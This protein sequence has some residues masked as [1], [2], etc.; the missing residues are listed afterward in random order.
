MS[1]RPDRAFFI[2]WGRRGSLSVVVADLAA[3][4]FNQSDRLDAVSYSTNNE[5]A[6]ELGTFRP[7]A[8]PFKTFS[9]GMGALTGL[10]RF[11]AEAQDLVSDLQA[12]GYSTAIVLMPHL[13]TPLLGPMLRRAGIRYTVVVHDAVRHPGDHT[14]IVTRWLLRDLN[15]ANL[16][17][18]LSKAV[19]DQLLAQRRVSPDRVAVVPHPA[20]SYSRSAG[21]RRKHEPLRVLFLGRIMA[22]K[23]LNI[24]V[25]AIESMR[26][27]GIRVVL[28]V[29]GEGELGNLGARLNRLGSVVVNR[30][31]NHAEIG[32]ILR[33]HHV[34]ALPYVEASQ[35]GVAAA[36]IGAGLPVVATPVGGLIEQVRHERTGLLAETVAASSLA[37]CLFRLANDNELY[38]RLANGAASQHRVD[39][40]AFA[41]HLKQLSLGAV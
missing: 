31:I 39:I 6:N 9:H 29:Y 2:F 25:E 35:S 14:G 40:P 12:K 24:L 4:L 10:P 19:R 3:F 26:R 11:R 8:L 18:T 38:E 20:L 36:A 22:Y 13:W 30:W 21:Q 23:G 5:L 34:L 37:E 33:S 28:S 7:A 16:V 15:H 27:E 1:P 17:I 32:D 41:R